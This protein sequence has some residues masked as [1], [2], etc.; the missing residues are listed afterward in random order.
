MNK[1]K[2][3]FLALFGL[4]SCNKKDVKISFRPIKGDLIVANGGDNS[5]T[6][7]DSK[8]YEVKNR[9]YFETNRTGFIH[10]IDISENKSFLTLAFPEYDFSLGHNTN[11]KNVPKGAIIQ[12]NI[13]SLKSDIFSEIIGA[14][15][16]ALFDQQKNTIYSQTSE[17]SGKLYSI[18]K[19]NKTR[20]EVSIGSD[21]SE[22]LFN[23]SL[24]ELYLAS[25]ED[26]FLEIYDAES[27]KLK[28]QIKVDAYP[29]G[30]FWGKNKSE[31]LISNAIKKAVNIVNL[32]IGKTVEAIDLDFSP[33]TVKRLNELVFIADYNKN[34]IHVFEKINSAWIRKSIIKTEADP[35]SFIFFDNNSKLAV[36]NQK[37]NSLQVFDSKS[38]DLL[39]TIKV[40][41]KPNDIIEF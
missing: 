27:L 40:G 36:V 21:V 28:K 25:E 23:S 39:K 9:F 16:D 5:L 38:L 31:V 20:K 29:S 24:S 7:I 4:F 32:T 15:H 19:S 37:S 13:L 3:V 14:N 33:G 12:L 18:N 35:H 8:S 10:H 1:F 17:E 22:M 11:M 26:S 41:S 6:L 34:N 30:L 2:L